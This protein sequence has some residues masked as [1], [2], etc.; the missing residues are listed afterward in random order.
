M[1]GIITAISLWKSGTSKFCVTIID[2]P[3]HRDFIKNVI[4]GTSQA[5]CAVL[6][7]AAGAGEFEAGISKSGHEHALLA[8]TLGVKQLIVGVKMGSME[9]PYS[10][11]RYEEIVKEVCA[12]IKKIV[13]S[14]DT[15]AFVPVP[16]WNL[17][18]MPEPSA[19]SNHGSRDGKSPVRMAMPMEPPCLKLWSASCHQLTQQTD[20]CVCPSK[21]SMKLVV[22]VLSL[23][24]VWRLMFSNLVWGSP[25][26]QSM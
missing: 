12:Y 1:H 14:P 19:N 6:T 20:T 23:W 4:T 26:L 8:C 25:L 18:N 3:G 7:V 22:F 9:P 24:V 21:M 17:D 15:V 2:A 10:Q 13:Y 16:G 11:K 5:D